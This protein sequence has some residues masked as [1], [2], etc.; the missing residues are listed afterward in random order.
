MED[1]N[2]PWKFAGLAI[3]VII[4]SL[5][6]KWSEREESKQSVEI[7]SVENVELSVGAGYLSITLKPKK[8]EALIVSGWKMVVGEAVVPFPPAA[9]LVYQGRVNQEKPVTITVPTTLILIDQESP[10]GVSFKENK[11]IGMLGH[12][13]KF[14]PALPEPCQ[15]CT[16]KVLDQSSGK[17]YPDYNQCVKNH[18][19]EP[20]FF[21]DRWR[22]YPSVDT[23]WNTNH[24]VIRLYDERGR[25]LDTYTY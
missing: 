12:F 3:L 4:L 20:D 2:V 8:G 15:S 25:L 13:Q 1:K 16:E 24:R 17:S 7:A 23:S 22:M 9:A 6:H 18:L 19:T 21:V 11:C 5:A 10:I 14:V